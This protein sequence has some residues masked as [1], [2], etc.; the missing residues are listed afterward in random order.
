MLPMKSEFRD[1]KRI[2]S[3]ALAVQDRRVW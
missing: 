2:A 3:I 1:G